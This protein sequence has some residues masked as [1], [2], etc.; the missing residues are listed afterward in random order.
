MIVLLPIIVPILAG[1]FLLAAPGWKN[2]KSVCIYTAAGLIL[3]GLLVVIALMTVPDN[4]Q[5]MLFQLTKSL[6]VFFKLDSIG[7][8]FVSL[9]VVIWV[10]CGMYSFRYMEHSPADGSTHDSAGTDTGCR[11]EKRFYGFYL[12]TFGVI[13]GLD[14]AGNL[15]TFYLFY[16]LMTLLTMP[17][18]L[19]NR[20]KEAIIAGLKYLFYSF[21][22]AYMAL[23]GFYFLNRYANTLS[24][25]EGGVLDMNLAAGHESLLLVAAFVMLLG[26]GVKAGM[27]PL[28]AWL[29][30]AH[31]VAP[32]PASAA[33]SGIIVKSGVLASIRVVFYLFG[34]EFLR[35]TWVQTAWLVLILITILMGSMMAYRE[36]LLKK[37]LAYSTVSQISYILLGIAL[38]QP[39]ALT[40]AILHTAAHAVTK[41]ALFLIAGAIIF[42]TGRTRVD[43]LNGIGRQMPVTLWCFTFASL[44]LIGI[45][46]ASGF[47][48]KWYLAMGSLKSGIPVIGILAPVVLLV[49][50][51]LTAGYLLPI[52]IRGFLPG[53][54]HGQAGVKEEGRKLPVKKELSALMLL[55]IVLLTALAILLGIFPNGLITIMKSVA[56]AV[57]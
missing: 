57:M 27:F 36:K 39:E 49:S 9:V 37:R 50:A 18:V 24:F 19:H 15:I 26:F 3:T 42:K 45:P 30:T 13:T 10:S 31:P 43:E 6:P 25:H 16:E 55:P 52:V 14:F 54:E 2:R 17:L 20:T 29:P 28:H 41:C 8:I 33:L 5:I 48:S 38:L 53:S 11:E 23:F 21:C 32:G 40:G 44:A 35:G 34:A 51:L 56:E 1:L 4:E 22:G 47:I 12:I 46:P 7:R